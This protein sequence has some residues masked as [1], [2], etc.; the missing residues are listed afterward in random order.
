MAKFHLFVIHD[1]ENRNIYSV[2]DVGEEVDMH[3]ID[4]PVF[5]R[6]ELSLIESHDLDEETLLIHC[7][8]KVI[9]AL[10][11]TDGWF[12]YPALY[13]IT[14]NIQVLDPEAYEQLQDIPMEY[15]NLYYEDDTAQTFM[16]SAYDTE[17]RSTATTEIN[18]DD[19]SLCISNS[20]V[21]TNPGR[22]Y[23]S[24]YS[25][26]SSAISSIVSC[27][28]SHNVD[29]AIQEEIE[30]QDTELVPIIKDESETVKDDDSEEGKNYINTYKYYKT[31]KRH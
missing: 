27:I 8:R 23:Y 24:S 15:V 20:S 25:N 10:M 19:E 3:F 21:F 11:T 31:F 28:R 1:V 16:D 26:I 5:V 14:V 22:S 17:I 9:R 18:D 29:N 30:D 7:Y 2:D 4:C 13:V 12:L 6:I